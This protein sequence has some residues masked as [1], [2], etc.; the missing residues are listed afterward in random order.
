M[1]TA[2]DFER[3][4]LILLHEWDPIGVTQMRDYKEATEDEYNGYA[5]EIAAMLARGASFED[6]FAYLKWASTENMGLSFF[7]EGKAHRA[8][9]LIV[10]A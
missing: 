5:R 4:R 6:V 8:A 9:E 10:Q 3:V 7:Q 2:A 1:T